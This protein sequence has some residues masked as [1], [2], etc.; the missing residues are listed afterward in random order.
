[1]LAFFF[2]LF[3]STVAFANTVTVSRIDIKGN[4]HTDSSLIKQYLY[5]EPGQECAMD[6]L[7]ML[8]RRSEKRLENTFYFYSARI[9]VAPLKEN[10][11]KI[12]VRI[13]E[14]FLFRFGGSSHGVSIGKE[15]IQGR[16][17]S[18][19]VLLGSSSLKFATQI[20]YFF[21]SP[22]F[23]FFSLSTLA[24]TQNI[25]GSKKSDDG[26]AYQ[27]KQISMGLGWQFT[28]DLH[29]GM[30]WTYNRNRF[31]NASLSNLAVADLHYAKIYDELNIYSFFIR[32]RNL[33]HYVHPTNGSDVTFYSE[34]YK[35]ARQGLLKLRYYEALYERVS[36]AGKMSVAASS[37]V[38]D[39]T[40]L[41]TLNHFNGL[42]TSATR[43]EYGKSAFLLSLDLDYLLARLPV[44]RGLLYVNG[45]YQMGKVHRQS[46]QFDHLAHVAGL[47]AEALF[48]YPINLR[49]MGRFG[50]SQGGS[51]FGW[52]ITATPGA[53][54]EL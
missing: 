22:L 14:G 45:F 1:M 26:L 33:N 37:G 3:F 27:E 16:G 8:A 20:P 50:F 46:L 25:T 21:N 15:N 10:K 6:E 39:L 52:T 2:A 28:P 53:M 4:S 42:T 38:P 40:R 34:A 17:L 11:V 35:G 5:I 43:R 9:L 7:K 51:Y 30:G 44:L 29:V 36:V 24:Q 18:V 48:P 23:I 13:Q 41:F 47:G 19:G 49:V 32:Y 31:K 12:L 54:N